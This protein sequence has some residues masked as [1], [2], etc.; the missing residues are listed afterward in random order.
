M[1]ETTNPPTTL[2]ARTSNEFKGVFFV[3]FAILFGA[4]AGIYFSTQRGLIVLLDNIHWTVSYAAAAWL[5]WIGVRTADAASRPVRRWFAVGLSAYAFGQLLWDIQVATGWNP[6]PGPS[7]F[8]YLWLG[9]CC[10]GGF[11]SALRAPSA[12]ANCRLARHLDSTP[13]TK[14]V[15]QKK[16]PPVFLGEDV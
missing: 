8:F 10:A 15:A 13:R 6:F 9:P 11:L 3:S 5:A 14:I 12:R 16:Y 1:A 4:F 7:D 2:P